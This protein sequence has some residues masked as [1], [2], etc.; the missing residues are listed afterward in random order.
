MKTLKTFDGRIGYLSDEVYYLN[1]DNTAGTTY[2]YKD[3][4]YVRLIS[5]VDGNKTPGYHFCS[6]YVT[7]CR[8]DAEVAEFVGFKKSEVLLVDD[9]DLIGRVVVVR[10]HTECELACGTGRYTHAIVA[11]GNPLVLVSEEGD[12]M[13][14]NEDAKDYIFL[15][16]ADKNIVKVARNRY[17]GRMIGEYK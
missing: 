5:G 16:K 11:N 4:T 1:L 10:D 12:M 2:D 8:C 9:K 3:G 7:V 14:E 13:W 6:E 17:Y 15:C